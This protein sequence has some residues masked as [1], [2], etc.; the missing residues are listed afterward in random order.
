[1]IVCIALLRLKSA[2]LMLIYLTL[3]NI[4]RLFGWLSEGFWDI[5]EHVEDEIWSL[6][7]EAL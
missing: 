6:E 1:M 5:R 7:N 2:G 3:A 4:E